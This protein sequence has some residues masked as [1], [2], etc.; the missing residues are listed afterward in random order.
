MKKFQVVAFITAAVLVSG[1]AGRS[2]AGDK[3][4]Q[5]AKLAAQVKVSKADAE[6]TAL[7]KVPGG[8]IKEAEL[9]KEAGKLVWSFD[10][11]TPGTKDITEVLVDAK[12]GDVVSM[13]RE[14]P[15][16][17]AEEKAAEARKQKKDEDDEKD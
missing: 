2:I 8:S 17:Q 14:T 7:G 5:P 11:T 4:G 15:E 6:K 13:D 1:L 3:A 9:E 16:K 12:T 10:I